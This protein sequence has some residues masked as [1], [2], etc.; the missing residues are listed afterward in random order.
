MKTEGS[1]FAVSA[2]SLAVRGALLLIFAAP[3]LAFAQQ[4]MSDEVKELVYPNSWFDMGG[5]VVDQS[6]TK[7]GEYNGLNDSGPYVLADFGVHA[8]NGYGME[9]GTMR[10]DASG[11]NLGTNS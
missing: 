4:V 3:T 1:R 7:F 8:G 6:S 10:L 2:L 11:R 5:L 9:G